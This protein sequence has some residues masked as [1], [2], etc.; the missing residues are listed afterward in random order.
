MTGQHNL[1]AVLFFD[2]DA[3]T[4]VGVDDGGDVVQARKNPLP[5]RIAL[6]QGVEALRL[7]RLFIA[8]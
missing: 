6:L 7:Q 5:H 3:D 2:L 1:M 8:A 4:G